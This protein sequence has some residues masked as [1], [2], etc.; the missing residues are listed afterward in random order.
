[1]THTVIKHAAN[2]GLTAGTEEDVWDNGGTYPWLTAAAPLRVAA[3]GDA[4]DDVAGLGAQQVTIYGL[5]ADL[6]E[7]EETLDTNGASASADTTQSFRRVNEV[8]VTRVGTYSAANTGDIN[9]ETN[10][11]GDVVAAVLAGYG[12]AQMSMYTVPAS[13][14]GAYLKLLHASVERTRLSDV[15]LWHR[16]NADDVAAPFPA[17]RVIKRF[18]GITGPVRYEANDFEVFMPKTDIWISAVADSG[19]GG[20]RISTITEFLVVD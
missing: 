13:A 6:N 7:I 16:N 3:G 15:I 8:H 20:S 4:A 11:G 19:G 2:P 18:L 17:K 14:R 9:I 10:P 5:D 1:M 12:S